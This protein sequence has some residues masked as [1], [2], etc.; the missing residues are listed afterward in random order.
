MLFELVKECDE[1]PFGLQAELKRR[2]K[3]R[4]GDTVVS[5]L[6]HDIYTLMSVLEG[7]EFT[8]LKDILARSK[9]QRSQSQSQSQ[10]P[11]RANKMASASCGCSAEVASLLNNL[12]NVKADVLNQK[13]CYAAVETVRSSEIQSL[14]STVLGLK[15]ELSTLTTT[16]SKAVT[17]IVFTAQQIESDKSL[18]VAK[19]RTEIRLL[20]DSVRDIQDSIDSAKNGRLSHSKTLVSDKR[21]KSSKSNKVAQSSVTSGTGNMNDKINDTAIRDPQS[22]LEAGSAPDSVSQQVGVVINIDPDS[23]GWL[24]RSEDHLTAEPQLGSVHPNPNSGVGLR[25]VAPGA[26]GSIPQNIVTDSGGSAAAGDPYSVRPEPPVNI[27]GAVRTSTSLGTGS[28]IGANFLANDNHFP[29]LDTQL[30]CT[31]KAL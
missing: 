31:E 11:S 5:K 23:G 6:A 21:K 4:N 29:P 2:V 18:G 19:L 28:Q 13:H 7:G 9:G 12:N 15:S 27:D 1:F 26:Q 30:T 24:N 25:Q 20:K 16:V 3:T 8:E 10:T 22:V 14:K 17:D